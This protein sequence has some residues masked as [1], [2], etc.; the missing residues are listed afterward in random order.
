MG[1]NQFSLLTQEEYEQFCLGERE[2]LRRRERNVRTV[3]VDKANIV[4]NLQTKKV[5][6]FIQ[7]NGGWGLPIGIPP[8][9]FYIPIP[10]T[11]PSW[12]WRLLPSVLTP[13]KDQGNCASCYAFA[14]TAVV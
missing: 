6:S 9:P 7:S 14:V 8:P 10:P 12:D 1:I 11:A 13:I 4:R 3:N 5:D 2:E